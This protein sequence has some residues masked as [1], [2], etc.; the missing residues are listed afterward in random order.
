MSNFV[1]WMNNT[2]LLVQSLLYWWQHISNYLLL[3]QFYLLY[4]KAESVV[5]YTTRTL[6]SIFTY[7]NPNF[8][9]SERSWVDPLT[10]KTYKINIFFLV[11]LALSVPIFNKKSQGKRAVETLA[12]V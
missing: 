8:P 11:P 12:K 4:F 2:F 7:C 3:S 1:D 9:L 6:T 10:Y 5:Y